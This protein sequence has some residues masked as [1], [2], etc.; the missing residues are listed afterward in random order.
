M[1]Q[2]KK[3]WEQHEQASFPAGHRNKTIEGVNLTLIDTELSGFVLTFIST[4][5]SLGARQHIALE[6]GISTLTKIIPQLEDDA[7]P[8][9][10]HLLDLCKKI[11]KESHPPK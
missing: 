9:F 4:G 1:E 8:Y 10:Q 2:I 5:G 3:L 7:K 11:L 6:K